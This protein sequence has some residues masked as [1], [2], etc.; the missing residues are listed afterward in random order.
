MDKK[1]FLILVNMKTRQK[2]SKMP[3]TI[4]RIR[5]GGK[6]FEVRVDLDQALKFKK[7]EISS[8][9]AE[10]DKVFTDIKKGFVASQSELEE[11]FGT[12]DV[13]EV[14]KKIVKSGEVQTTQDYRDAEQEKKFKQ[15]VD[16]LVV[17]S[18]D[19]QTEFCR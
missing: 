6:H 2:I 8:V 13:N 9:E 4:A 18:V 1:N 5:H 15:I 12:N 3:S 14:V 10:T 17:N 7:G 19:P 16:F 11:A